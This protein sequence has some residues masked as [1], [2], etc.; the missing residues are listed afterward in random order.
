[1]VAPA[2]GG[3][4]HW[5]TR[6][7]IEAAADRKKYNDIYNFSIICVYADFSARSNIDQFSR[8]SVVEP[9]PIN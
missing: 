9:Q 6:K 7:L 5:L 8:L 2:G 4:I 1:M 3:I